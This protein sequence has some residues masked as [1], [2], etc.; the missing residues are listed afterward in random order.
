[1]HNYLKPLVYSLL[2]FTSLVGCSKLERY[3]SD[4][5]YIER[6]RSHK[7][8]YHSLVSSVRLASDSVFLHDSDKSKN[9][10]KYHQRMI[11]YRKGD[12]RLSKET[13][14]LCKRLNISEVVQYS[15][16]LIAFE[17]PAILHDKYIV[18]YMNGQPDSVVASIDS[19][20]V[21][22]RKGKIKMAMDNQWYLVYKWDN[23]VY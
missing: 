14:L 16:S 23:T 7:D 2:I 5:A 13:R 17:Y 6:Y 21:S 3:L 1:M 15:D 8:E 10:P 18:H 12:E 20:D 22:T 11:W 4:E 19:Y 9:A